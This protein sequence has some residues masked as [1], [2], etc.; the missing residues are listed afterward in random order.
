MIPQRERGGR[1]PRERYRLLYLTIFADMLGDLSQGMAFGTD[2]VLRLAE[3]RS[4]AARLPGPDEIKALE[5]AALAKRRETM[6]PAEVRALAV[7]AIAHLHEV[8]DSSPNFRR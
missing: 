3:V 8:A 6:A 5:G 2:V 1:V 7:K 4:R